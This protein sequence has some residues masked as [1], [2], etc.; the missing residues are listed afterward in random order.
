MTRGKA[1]LIATDQL[2][3]TIFGGWPDETISS[4]AWRWDQDGVRHWPR[5][6]IDALFFWEADHCRQSF[7][8]ERAGAQL[9]PEAR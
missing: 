6:L 7:E 3:N 1:V 2:I 4:R 9:P 5:R 8:A